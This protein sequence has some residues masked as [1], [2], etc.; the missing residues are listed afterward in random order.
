MLFLSGIAWHL[1]VLIL[2]FT[3]TL[4]DI[5]FPFFALHTLLTFTTFFFLCFLILLKAS[6]YIWTVGIFLLLPLTSL[7]TAM[8]DGQGSQQDRHLVRKALK[9][10]L[11]HLKA[12]HARDFLSCHGQRVCALCFPV[13]NIIQYAF[14]CLLYWRN[15]VASPI[16]AKTKPHQIGSDQNFLSYASYTAMT[17]YLLDVVVE[18]L[19]NDTR[20]TK[21]L[22][23]T[24][25]F[26]L[27][28][29]LYIMEIPISMV[30]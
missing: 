20:I 3:L 17:S 19:K 5:L 11:S 28:A 18:L 16:E 15:F 7:A 9:S 13:T 14:E 23:Y 4:N 10:A 29:G 25:C 21:Y 1:L 2:R 22:C 6:I 24:I 26:K 30:K 12:N 8:Q 27:D